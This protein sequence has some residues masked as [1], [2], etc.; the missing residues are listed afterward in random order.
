MTTEVAPA[1]RCILKAG[2][3]GPHLFVYV[4]SEPP[5]EDDCLATQPAIVVGQQ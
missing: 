4:S 3:D 2:H 5:R 1:R